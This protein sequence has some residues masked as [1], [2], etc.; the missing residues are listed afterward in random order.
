MRLVTNQL[1]GLMQPPDQIHVF[2]KAQTFVECTD[3]FDNLTAYQECGGW[4]VRNSSTGHHATLA[5]T[6]IQGSGTRCISTGR[7][8]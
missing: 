5:A 7:H 1:A 3:L 8:R 2:P 4:N 6:Q